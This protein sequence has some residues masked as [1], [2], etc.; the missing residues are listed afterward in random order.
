MDCDAIPSSLS[1]SAFEIVRKGKG[2]RVELVDAGSRLLGGG[3]M[4]LQRL[5]E[6]IEVLEVA[7]VAAG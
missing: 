6:T 4:R 5:K 2:R 3:D 1:P 7:G